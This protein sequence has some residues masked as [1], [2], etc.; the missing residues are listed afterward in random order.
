[1]VTFLTE[2]CWYLA[3]M[4]LA[5]GTALVILPVALVVALSAMWL[6]DLLSSGKSPRSQKVWLVLA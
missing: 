1:M 2:A 6:C 4:G 3:C 5:V